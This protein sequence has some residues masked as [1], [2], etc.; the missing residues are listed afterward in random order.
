MP[1]PF[2]GGYHN[3]VAQQSSR[4]RRFNCAAPFRGRLLAPSDSVYQVPGVA[5]IVPPPFGGGYEVIHAGGQS[6]G[7]ASIVPRSDLHTWRGD[8]TPA[9]SPTAMLQLCRPLS[10]AVTAGGTPRMWR[11]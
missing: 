10:G 11:A 8:Q 3:L 6:H 1:P 2:G 4:R 5:S 9:A 7:H